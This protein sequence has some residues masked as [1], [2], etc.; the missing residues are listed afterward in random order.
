MQNNIIKC[1]KTTNNAI[2]QQNKKEKN[3]GK[4]E[5][6]RKKRKEK[7]RK[8]GLPLPWG[9]GD[10]PQEDIEEGTNPGRLGLD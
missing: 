2:K 10:D 1:I 8:E 3:K 9:D 5:K 7:R 4:K 6:E